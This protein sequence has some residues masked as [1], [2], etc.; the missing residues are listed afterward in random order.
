MQINVRRAE[1]DKRNTYIT[2]TVCAERKKF[3]GGLK[4]NNDSSAR[5]VRFNIVGYLNS[6]VGSALGL[7][8]PHVSLSDG[9]ADSSLSALNYSEG[10]KIGRR[11]LCV[12]CEKRFDFACVRL[13]LLRLFT[14]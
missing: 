7:D 11:W 2:F 13:W 6:K 8:N 5:Q 14:S 1:S 9:D 3:L 4:L 12:D 10:F